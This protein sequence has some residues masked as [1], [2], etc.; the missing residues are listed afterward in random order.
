MQ[1]ARQSELLWHVACNGCVVRVRRGAPRAT[2]RFER[3]LMACATLRE[4]RTNGV[5]AALNWT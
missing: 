4:R 1:L 5:R 3:M 2:Q